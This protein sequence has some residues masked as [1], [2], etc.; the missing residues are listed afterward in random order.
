[1]IP[2]IVAASLFWQTPAKADPNYGKVVFLMEQG[3]CINGQ[4]PLPKIVGGWNLEG[5]FYRPYV[6]GKWGEV[7]KPPITPQGAPSVPKRPNFG[8][9][10]DKK[11]P[12]YNV[13]GHVASAAE[14]YQKLSLSDDSGKPRLTLIDSDA[15]VPANLKSDCLIWRVPRG[16]WSVKDFPPG[17]SAFLTTADGKT[18]YKGPVDFDAITSALDGKDAA[19]ATPATEL[20]LGWIALGLGAL[21]LF[22]RRR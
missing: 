16:H 18:L 2:L 20:P 6:D 15:E 12:A 1:M 7:T 8:V 17:F 13:N 22:W 3:P 10:L 9:D 11:S 5:R 21:I 14:A 19:P 4:C